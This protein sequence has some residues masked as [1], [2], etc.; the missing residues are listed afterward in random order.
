M[1]SI[2]T[3]LALVLA[4]P[5]SAVEPWS[6]A[7]ESVGTHLQD[8]SRR[9]ALADALAADRATAEEAIAVLVGLTQDP[10]VGA[11]ARSKLAT[12]LANL[13]PRAG[14]RD[15]Y[16]LALESTSDEAL[17]TSLSL[18]RA[19]ADVSAPRTRKTGLSALTALAAKNPGRDDVALGLAHGLLLAG[20]A[21]GAER[22]LTPV[23]GRAEAREAML[24]AA[25]SGAVAA[26]AVAWS[27][28]ASAAGLATSG[29]ID[30]VALRDAFVTA[31]G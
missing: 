21:V 18:R 1:R 14:W 22:A 2:C 29:A 5:A 3:L 6:T 9:L 23:L 26:D 13:P 20:D 16:A 4:L 11:E 7:A 10:D 17:R 12:R 8:R 24:L 30:P 25:L 19:L 15:L 28:R 31:A 27:Q